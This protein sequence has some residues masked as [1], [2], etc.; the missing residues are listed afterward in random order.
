MTIGRGEKVALIGANGSGKSTLLRLIA[1][2]ERPDS[3]TVHVDGVVSLLEQHAAADTSTALE[4]VVP[5]ELEAARAELSRAEAALA[6]PSAE[7][8]TRFGNAE[9]RFRALGGYEFEAQ[10]EATL[11]GLG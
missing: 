11:T 8:L 5:A 7:N 1:G 9:E 6:E 4:Q 3:G 2:L 10:A